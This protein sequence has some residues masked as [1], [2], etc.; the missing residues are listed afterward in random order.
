MNSDSGFWKE[1]IRI[2]VLLLVLAPFCSSPRPTVDQSSGLYTFQVQP[3]QSIFFFSPRNGQ[4]YL[5]PLLKLKF[6][7]IPFSFCFCCLLPPLFNLKFI[8]IPNSEI[9]NISFE[10]FCITQT[11][12]NGKD[13]STGIYC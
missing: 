4:I 1:K 8:C 12:S 10:W 6:I 5:R 13:S 2:I 11:F 7:L 9:M 3:I